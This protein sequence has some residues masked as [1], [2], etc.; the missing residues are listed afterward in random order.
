[1]VVA[2]AVWFAAVIPAILSV[3]AIKVAFKGREEG[4]WT[5]PAAPGLAGAVVA[6]AV[7]A[8]WLLPGW[9][10]ELLA[11]LPPALAV[12]ALGVVRPHPRHLK[13]VGW[14][15]VAANALTLVLLLVL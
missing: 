11:V 12:I 1:A 14:T 2:A 15:M 6:G 13:R 5:L 10:T 4:R 3:H 9:A 8:A 7:V